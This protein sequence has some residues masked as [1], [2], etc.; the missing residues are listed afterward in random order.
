M[1]TN[2]WILPRHFRIKIVT[3]GRMT[4]YTAT[5]CMLAEHLSLQ[6]ELNRGS[7]PPQ[8]PALLSECGLSQS[9]TNYFSSLHM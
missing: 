2:H 6:L 5:V 7:P 1:R 3:F 4:N 8:P 9:I